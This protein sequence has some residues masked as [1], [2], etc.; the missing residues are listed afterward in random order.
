V[1]IEQPGGE[2][3]AA[4]R[5]PTIYGTTTPSGDLATMHGRILVGTRTEMDTWPGF[6]IGLP[7]DV[8]PT[9]PAA[10][11]TRNIGEASPHVEPTAAFAAAQTQGSA[12]LAGLTKR[13]PSCV[14]EEDT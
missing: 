14:T 5:Y 11:L 10:S 7:D 13:F 2:R 12:A 8:S 1:F 4:W 6:T 3:G 9:A